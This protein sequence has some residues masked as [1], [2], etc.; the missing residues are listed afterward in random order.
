MK[1]VLFFL[2]FPL[3]S[4]AQ[5]IDYIKEME[6]N[7]LQIR[8]KPSTE[9][10]LSNFLRS[11]GIKEDTI[12]AI[13]YTPAECYRCEAAIPAFYNKLK[14]NSLHNKMLLIS[15]Y[16]DSV[17][18][19][20][21]NKKNGYKS[22]YYLYDTKLEY[23]RIF[24]F[25]SVAMYGLYI[26]KICPKTGILL[27]GGQ[28]TLLGKDFINQLVA[29]K[30][31]LSPHLYP[32][33]TEKEYQIKTF[34]DNTKY[35]PWK[36]E[37][38]IIETNKDFFISNIYDIPKIEN[39][40][41]FFTDMLNNGVMLFKLKDNRYIY[42][43]LFQVNDYEKKR[44]V[45]VSDQQYKNLVAA[46]QVFNIALSSN[47]IDDKHL[48]IS[49][50]LPKILEEKV[51]GIINLSFYNAPAILIRNIEDF[52]SEDMI[53]PDFNLSNSDYFYMHFSFDIFNNKLWVG[54]EKLTWP[55][56]GFEKEDIEGNIE[57]NP[58]D[59]RFYDTFNPIIASFDIN[60]GKCNG[61]YGNLDE[62][63]RKSR[64]GYYFLNNVFA[65]YKDNY[66][67]GNGYTGK[68][69][70]SS[71]TDTTTTCYEVF[72]V[73]SSQFAVPDS[74]KFYKL[75]YGSLYDSNF[76]KCITAVKMNDKEI[77]CLV[78]HGKPRSDNFNNDRYSF[79]II[80]R[81]SGKIQERFLP[82]IDSRIKSL[83]YG[84]MNEQNEFNPFIFIKDDNDYKILKLH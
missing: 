64:T 52:Q 32:G 67:Y 17:A 35:Y 53:T 26:M 20:M 18:A 14:N 2:M 33:D 13:L 65:H 22:D 74:S 59:E 56:D 8:Q 73:N 4:F 24:S 75:E 43:T 55:M 80:N 37:E 46:G 50:S 83:G 84:I 66:L 39:G 41:L 45:S 28:Y 57:I 60:S 23:K 30:N 12:Y 49:Y 27:T 82:A 9:V 71:N 1:W 31:R 76:S 51:D 21:Y 54:C 29:Y 36:T 6:N 63:Q 72:D 38:Y 15:A 70:L 81:I 79:V 68:L 19:A 34:E 78:K 11:T 16:T 3:I 44:F 40:N 10:L 5:K 58:F 42:R 7:D 77:C 61:H 48:A 25:N 69:Y 47:M 62:S